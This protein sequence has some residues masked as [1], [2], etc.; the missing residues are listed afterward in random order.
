MNLAISAFVA[1]QSA[2]FCFPSDAFANSQE[3]SSPTC[4]GFTSYQTTREAT[5]FTSGRDRLGTLISEEK[6]DAK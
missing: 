1:I 6:L 4:S 3:I 2:R 5:K